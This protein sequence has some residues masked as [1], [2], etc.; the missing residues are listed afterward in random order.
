M[1]PIE[2]FRANKQNFY[3]E[4]F[5]LLRIASIT[6]NNEDVEVA[7]EWLKKTLEQTADYVEII[8]TK[9]NPVVLAEWKPQIHQ[10]DT[11]TL[12][13][14]GHYDVQP[15]EPL[16]KWNSPP[17]EPEIREGRIYARGVGDNKGQ[18]YAHYCAIKCL[19]KV[20]EL[21]LSVKF[22]FDGEEE[23]GSFHL[24]DAMNTRREFFDDIDL[25]LVSDGPADPSWKPTL[26]FG[27]RGIQTLR[28]ELQSA[29]SDVH[30]GN[31]GGIQPNPAWDLLAILQTMR[32]ENGK[33]LIEGFYDDVF[34]PT[35]AA[36]KAAENLNRDPEIYKKQ[37]GIS[38]FGEEQDQPLT[39]RVMFRP[40]L[41]IRGFKS[42]EIRE[43]A[44]NIIPREAVVEIDIR[45]VPNQ[46]PEKMES[47]ILAHLDKLR[48]Q[49]ERMAHV[50]DKCKISFGASFQPLFTPLE[51][52]WTKV[53]S[54]AIEEGFGQKPLK[55]LLAGG[56]LPLYS[57]YKITKKPIY[58]IPY[59]QPDEANHAPNEN[60]MTEWFDKGV[61]TSIKLLQ[62]LAEK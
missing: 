31:F 57:L 17:F 54:E 9:G 42:G 61:K 11:P 23:L 41:N 1:K 5:E 2:V 33:C 34:V 62:K 45:M 51:L 38:Y 8:Q 55:L 15:P 53:L 32:D 24:E 59:A 40:T 60:L 58:I 47:L 14:Y 44:K 4:L 29:D 25:I 56:S 37:L 13:F 19:H 50:L 18:F 27:A 35:E 46:T 43:N 49:S 16:D 7:A 39:H 20:N 12:L 21:G 10:K 30:S 26:E 6:K 52:P 36:L 22:I 3:D 48:G 28:I